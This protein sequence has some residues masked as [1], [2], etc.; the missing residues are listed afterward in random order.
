MDVFNLPVD[1]TRESICLFLAI[2]TSR[3]IAFDDDA[4]D[5]LDSVEMKKVFNAAAK[6]LKSKKFDIIGM[7]ACLMSMIETGLQVSGAGKIFCGSQEIEPGEGWPYDRIL[8]ALSA[9][10]DMDAPDLASLIAQ[11]F[12]GSYPKTE[13]VTQSAFNLAAL[14]QVQKAADDLGTALA[15]AYKKK[16][17]ATQGAIND[18]RM[19]SQGYAHPDYVDLVDFSQ[20]VA[21][22]LPKLKPLAA[23]VGKAVAACVIANFAPNAK[24]GG[25]HG[26]S[27]YLP[28]G[29]ISPLYAKLDFAKGGWGSFLSARTQ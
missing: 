21:V 27:I 9:K 29:A 1:G 20:F 10:P 17:F 18:A 4:Q 22:N 25:S 28:T 15:K 11:E 7:D 16:D 12:V 19:R 6:K 14:K 26:L 3:A 2:F 5:F 23:K 13:P 24:V 8:R